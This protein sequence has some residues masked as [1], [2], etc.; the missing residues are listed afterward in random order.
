VYRRRI[1]NRY[2]YIRL[3]DKQWNLRASQDDAFRT[4][5]FRKTLNNPHELFLGF[6]FDLAGAQLVEDNRINTTPTDK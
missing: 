6:L 3:F 5:V 4:F 2:V 1:E